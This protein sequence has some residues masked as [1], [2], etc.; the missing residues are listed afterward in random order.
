MLKTGLNVAFSE[1]L[2]VMVEIRVPISL[3]T[4][5][6]NSLLKMHNSHRTLVK[7]LSTGTK[8]L[9][10]ISWILLKHLRKEDTI[11]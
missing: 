11:C 5:S 6:I 10:I 2:T 9:K 1:Y 8:K 3:G 4:I 7:Q